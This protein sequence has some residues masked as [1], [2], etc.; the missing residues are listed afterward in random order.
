VNNSTRTRR[1]TRVFRWE[2]P[3]E[4]TRPVGLNAERESRWAET[5]ARL[6]LNPGR[7]AIIYEG[8]QGSCGSLAWSIRRGATLG[9]A[10][11]NSFESVTRGPDAG[12]VRVYARYVGEDGAS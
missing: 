5:V 1:N 12:L 3:P 4:S 7:W 10:P 2:D 11:P 6:Q 9:F 8:S